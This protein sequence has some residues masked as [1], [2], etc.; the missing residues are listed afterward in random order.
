MAPEAISQL[1]DSLMP[2]DG[3]GDAAALPAVAVAAPL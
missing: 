3:G 1:L 2:E